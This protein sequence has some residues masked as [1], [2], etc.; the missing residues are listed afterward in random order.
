M[1]FLALG[2]CLFAF[3][4]FSFGQDVD[5]LG[6]NKQA[7]YTLVD[8]PN[9]LVPV[10]L[11]TTKDS[12]RSLFQ[13]SMYSAP[14]AS[15]NQDTPAA[16]TPEVLMLLAEVIWCPK[17]EALNGGDFLVGYKLDFNRFPMRGTSNFDVN[18]IRFRLTYVRRSSII[19][20]TPR[21]DFLPAKLK[22]MGQN[23]IPP[24]G[25]A[26]DR[27]ITLSNLKQVG[28][29]LMLF[30]SDYDD[31]LPYVQSTPQLFT[32]LN[33]YLKNE[34]VFKTKNPMGGSFRFNMSLAGVSVTD[35]ENP[36]STPLV[37]ESEAWPDGKRGICYADSHAKFVTADE[38][39]A[40][41]PL[42]KLKLK[43]HGK[44]IAPG[45]PLPPPMK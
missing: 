22:E 30:L 11:A 24:T 32:F 40:M 20:I 28:T 38:W 1:R 35:I 34:E 6:S 21:E 23:K 14:I 42:L 25:T 37:Y 7:T 45:A 8:L 3:S 43:R 41:Q 27:T 5:L 26:T 4:G 16:F 17:I 13:M 2:V 36:A 19:S 15:P 29:A 39:N 44:P 9:D 18:S 31:K 33:P 12:L 10:E